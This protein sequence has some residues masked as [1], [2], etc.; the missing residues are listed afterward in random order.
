MIQNQTLIIKNITLIKRT[1]LLLT[2]LSLYQIR[3]AINKVHTDQGLH[4]HIKLDN[5]I[6]NEPDNIKYI[7]NNTFTFKDSTP[8]NSIL[9]KA[10]VCNIKQILT[11][12]TTLKKKSYFAK[13]IVIK[14]TDT[15][16]FLEKYSRFFLLRR[17][18]YLYNIYCKYFCSGKNDIKEEQYFCVVDL[19]FG[20]QSNLMVEIFKNY[21]PNSDLLFI[22]EQFFSLK[23]KYNLEDLFVCSFI[24]N[25]IKLCIKP[26]IKDL[27]KLMAFLQCVSNL[28]SHSLGIYYY[29]PFKDYHIKYIDFMPFIV[30]LFLYHILDS[31]GDSSRILGIFDADLW[32]AL[33]LLF[34][35]FPCS[36]FLILKYS[37]V[38][39]PF[40]ILFFSVVNPLVGFIF[41]C[42]VCFKC[43]IQNI[44]G[45][46][47]GS[48]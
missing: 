47:K 46:N 41:A 9:I 30:L 8:L 39:T 22:A 16:E 17:N 42:F 31:L 14:I 35:K 12:Y 27:S 44:K 45:K 24:I 6:F 40:L 48:V 10:R 20:N 2:L 29:L 5:Y 13:N 1:L 7:K 21:R 43:I 38:S 37:G 33:C 36:L 25:E 26:D 23:L 3:P 34:V 32:I 18:K 19:K 15:E 4:E 28:H 11:I